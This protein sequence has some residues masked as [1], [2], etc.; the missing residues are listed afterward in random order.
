MKS[1][2]KEKCQ[3]NNEKYYEVE[4]GKSKEKCGA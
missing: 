4:V 3:K 2:K 1:E